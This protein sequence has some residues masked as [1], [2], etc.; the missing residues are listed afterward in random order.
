MPRVQYYLLGQGE[1]KSADSW[2]PANSH[3]QTYYLHSGGNANSSAGDGR[4]EITLPGEQKPDAFTYDP[5]NPV[6]SRGGTVCCTGNPEDQSGIFDQSDIELR[7][8]VLV[9]TGDVL[10]D[11]LTLTGPVGAVL[12]VSSSARD[13]DFTLKLV[14]VW[15]D[16]RAYNIQDSILRARYRE[17]FDTQI[18]MTRGEIYRLEIKMNDTAYVL[19]AGHRLRLEISS[20]NF[21]RSA[22]N[23]NT[24][25]N[26]YDETK[27]VVAENTIYHSAEYPSHLILPVVE[28]H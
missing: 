28:H 5:G 19:K 17:G 26:N 23:L 7:Q 18:M 16:G 8:D 1:W 2:P 6:P 4:L 13:T 15:P 14:D 10:E 20:S 25:G 11:N 12:W 9:Y 22:R 24:G 27:W 3:G 21:P